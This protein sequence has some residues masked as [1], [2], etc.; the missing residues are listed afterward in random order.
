MQ[1]AKE[2]F[3]R[4]KGNIMTSPL[5]CR[6]VPRKHYLKKESSIG[7]EDSIVWQPVSEVSSFTLSS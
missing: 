2:E 3:S 5:I 4:I 1:Q 6:E 7:D